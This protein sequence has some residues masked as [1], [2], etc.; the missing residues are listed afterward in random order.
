[1]SF[2]PIFVGFIILSSLV[3][4]S[5]SSTIQSYL[6]LLIAFE[7]KNPRFCF[8][9]PSPFFFTPFFSSSVAKS[10]AALSSFLLPFCNFLSCHR[11]RLLFRVT[12]TLFFSFFTLTSMRFNIFL[13]SST[14]LLVSHP[15]HLHFA[16]SSHPASLFTAQFP[17]TVN[18]LTRSSL[19]FPPFPRQCIPP[20]TFSS[21][22]YTSAAFTFLL[23]FVSPLLQ[24][25]F[26]SLLTSVVKTLPS[27]FP[28]SPDN[29]F[30]LLSTF[31]R[32]SFFTLLTPF[33]VLSAIQFSF[34]ACF[35]ASN[36]PNCLSHFLPQCAGSRSVPLP[37]HSITGNS[38]FPL[39]VIHVFSLHLFLRKPHTR[40][41]PPLSFRS[42]FPHAG[43]L[44]RF[45]HSKGSS[46]NRS[47]LMTLFSF[48]LVIA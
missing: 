12:L 40:F 14:S 42:L 9:F 19:C 38:C 18:F 20:F 3:T 21:S 35:H 33:S 44:F 27:P 46:L 32:S 25:N 4:A 22:S 47:L 36:S 23:L 41:S 28:P 6:L 31:S 43:I 1:M 17:L 26:P 34:S 48:F 5:L 37:I 45:L 29:S 39:F 13:C 2:F 10:I 8:P 24:C 16:A 11:L 15:P 7:L 30:S